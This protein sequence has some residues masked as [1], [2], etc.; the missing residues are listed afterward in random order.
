MS[1]PDNRSVLITF[2][3]GGGPVWENYFVEGSPGPDILFQRGDSGFVFIL[4]HKV[5]GLVKIHPSTVVL[6]KRDTEQQA[7]ETIQM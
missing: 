4:Q 1:A 7:A 6:I 3:G 2:S 5:A